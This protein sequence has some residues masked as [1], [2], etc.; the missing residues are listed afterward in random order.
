MIRVRVASNLTM[1]ERFR[2]GVL[3]RAL[4]A[5][6]AIAVLAMPLVASAQ[7]ESDPWENM[8]R[9][10]FAFNEGFDTWVLIPVAN[11]WDF[12][13]PEPV[14]TG[15]DNVFKNAAMVIVMG[16]DLLQ[17][18]PRRA[19]EDLGRLVTNTTVGIGGI[20]DVATQV[21]IPQNDEDFGQTLG[22]WGVPPGP[23]LVLPILGPS[24][25]RDTFGFAV[26]TFSQPWAW[27]VPLYTSVPVAMFEY[28]NLRTIY[29]EEIDELHE[30]ALDYYVFQ[31]NAYA[32]DRANAVN[33]T[34]SVESEE[35]EDLYYF[36]EEE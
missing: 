35:A 5:C 3:H 20:F 2:I 24:N 29:L 9:G 18:K 6:V 28:L 22:Y 14:Q 34:E 36:D 23:Y 7:D 11:A 26:D 15:L 1:F 17:L 8:N 4:P 27:F 19:I 25:P 32:Q 13:A 30:A 21:G 12:V 10:T 33:D 16:N 31:R